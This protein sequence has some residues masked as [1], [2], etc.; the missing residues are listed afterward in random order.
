MPK[1]RHLRIP[2]LLTLAGFALTGCLEYRS[3]GAM[4]DDQNIEFRVIEAIAT[5]DAIDRDS[6]IKVEVYE[7]VVLLMGEAT[8]EAV[9]N[10]AGDLAAN[11]DQVERV[12]NE[13]EVTERVGVGGKFNNSWLTSKVNTKLATENTLEGWDP[14]RIKVISSRKTVY[15]MG[16]VTRDEGDRVAEVVRNVRG[17]E[18]VVKVFNYEKDD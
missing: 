7:N 4:F 13:I 10:R 12:V 15:L 17:V 18:K 14:H 3:T 9:R 6:H 1:I 8:T 2:L 5:S 11:V 16:N